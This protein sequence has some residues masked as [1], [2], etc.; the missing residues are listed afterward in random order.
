MTR[1]QSR[2]EAFK[3]LYQSDISHDKAED[4][5]ELFYQQNEGI[6]DKAKS[7]ISNVIFGVELNKDEIDKTITKYSKGWNLNRISKLSAAALRLAIFEIMY[8]DDIPNTVAASEAVS[9]VKLYDSEESAGFV[10]GILASVIGGIP[11]DNN[12]QQFLTD[13]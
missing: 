2:D 13:I 6:N 12:G 11:V 8:C 5:L 1:K 7:Y 3:L 9:L 10:N 4:I